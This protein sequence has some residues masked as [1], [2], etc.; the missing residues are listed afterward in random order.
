MLR[1]CF[2]WFDGVCVCGTSCVGVD[3]FLYDEKLDLF[4]W[5]CNEL[6][7]VCMA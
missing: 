7:E 1:G 3:T 5:E 4:L 2:L 6:Y